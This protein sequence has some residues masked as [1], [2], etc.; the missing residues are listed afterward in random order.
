M[1]DVS[2]VPVIESLSRYKFEVKLIDESILSAQEKE[3]L[4][5]WQDS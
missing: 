1:K 5:D 2:P 4:K 3:W